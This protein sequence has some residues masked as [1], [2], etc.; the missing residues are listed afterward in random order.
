V[1]LRNIAFCQQS[2][3][4]ADNRPILLILFILIEMEVVR[5]EAAGAAKDRY[6]QC[7]STPVEWELQENRKKRLPD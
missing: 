4:L 3:K 7:G 2:D 5:L 1:Q 6:L